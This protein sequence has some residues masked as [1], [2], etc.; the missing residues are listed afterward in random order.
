MVTM[1]DLSSNGFVLS[2]A[3]G[4][5][6]CVHSSVSG[7]LKYPTKE[8]CASI[9]AKLRGSGNFNSLVSS[10]VGD[11]EELTSEIRSQAKLWQGYLSF[12]WNWVPAKNTFVYASVL[13]T[14]KFMCRNPVIC[15]LLKRMCI[16]AWLSFP[17]E[18]HSL[19]IQ[20]YYD[21]LDLQKYSFSVILEPLINDVII[22]E[23][24]GLMSP[25]MIQSAR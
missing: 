2:Q 20:T 12:T 4:F 1:L 6:S 7:L 24:Q 9:V 10:V 8:M 19:Q 16:K 13:E 3:A 17:V 25:Y 14:L 18:R 11:L 21:D 15:V 22:L 23:S 5:S